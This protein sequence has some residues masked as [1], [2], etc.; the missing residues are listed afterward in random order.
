MD[1]AEEFKGSPS[2]LSII[3]MGSVESYLSPQDEEPPS[4]AVGAPEPCHSS[5]ITWHEHVA[6]SF[7]T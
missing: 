4:V 6:I 2:E 5:T 1:L 3:Q 7:V